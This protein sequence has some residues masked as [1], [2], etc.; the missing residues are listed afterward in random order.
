MDKKMAAPHKSTPQISAL[1][2]NLSAKVIVAGKQSPKT[3][4]NSNSRYQNLTLMDLRYI[5]FSFQ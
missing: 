1:E 5:Y 3:A 2:T 4:R